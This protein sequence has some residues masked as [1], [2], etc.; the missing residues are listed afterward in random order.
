MSMPDATDLAALVR[1]GKASPAELVED[2]INRVKRLDP[3]LNAVILPRFDAARAEA[4][5]ALPDG[6]LRGVPFLV[7]DL[8]CAMAGEPH[9]QGCAG[10]K[11]SGYTAPHD[12]FLY[13][14]FKRLGL[15]ALGRT[16]TPEF[17]STVTT[18]P[19]AYG[20]TRNPWNLDHSTGGS[21]GGS[22]AAVAAGLVP[23]AHA[24][25][26]GGSIRVPASECGLVGLK[27]TRGRVSHGPDVG[28]A[29]AGA[30]IDGVV[31][32]SVRDTATVLDGISGP[33]PGDPYFAAPP[34][35]PFADEVGV[36]PGRL[37]IGLAPAAST[38]TTDP[39]C[40]AAVEN[41]GRL[42]ESLGHHVELAQPDAMWEDE[43]GD[44]FIKILACATAA[45]FGSWEEAIGRP[46]A[47]DDVEPS[48]WQFNEIGKTITAK[49]YLDSVHWLHGWQRRFAPWW[50]DDGGFD[51]LV[52][53]TLA[54]P[55]PRIGWLTDPVAG[56][57]RV[58]EILLFT[59]QF[60]VS[61][62]PAV[63]LPLHQSADGL[64]VGVQFAG[65][66]GDESLLL[67]LASQL[68]AA[69]PWSAPTPPIWAG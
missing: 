65:P 25:D 30:T 19:V 42:L 28:E 4:D 8:G 10:L 26:G 22:A 43:F 5:G 54:V 2:A 48:N 44:H 62:Q 63:S 52:T 3:E 20:P 58:G 9:H 55:P 31:T 14:R 6:P 57:Q 7:K 29:W 46:F 17:G 34:A 15:I 38:G 67:R 53:P 12:S 64:P 47:E 11:A 61:G 39:E 1:T 21:S 35:R 18:E 51:I 27:P 45:D 68:E 37:R 32:R 36:D 33:E 40:I 49:A 69:A 24:N 66:F 56:Q 16:N 41:A 23:V 50:E 60:N 13:Q 59:V